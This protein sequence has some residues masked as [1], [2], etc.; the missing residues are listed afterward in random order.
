MSQLAVG[1]WSPLRSRDLSGFFPVHRQSVAVRQAGRDHRVRGTP[2][3]CVAVAARDRRPGRERLYLVGTVPSTARAVRSMHRAARLCFMGQGCRE[4][5]R[6]YKMKISG[7]K[8]WS[9]RP[10]RAI[11]GGRA[12]GGSTPNFNSGPNPG[13]SGAREMLSR[14]R[15]ILDARKE[16]GGEVE[17]IETQVGQWSS[18]FH[19]PRP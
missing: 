13:F 17:D 3:P 12:N 9:A 1:I 11:T 19:V 4:L 16:G 7:A 14:G 10:K 15:L 6:Q 2:G 5:E 18:D 8:Q